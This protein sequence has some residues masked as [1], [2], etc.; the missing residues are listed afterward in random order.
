MKPRVYSMIQTDARETL[1][2]LIDEITL[3]LEDLQQ[4]E[5]R[6]RLNMYGEGEKTA[7]VQMLEFIQ[8]RWEESDAQGL[9][10]DIEEIFPV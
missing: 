7:F 8:Q 2:D 9:D 10:Y 3:A 1:L 5:R 6:G 4:E